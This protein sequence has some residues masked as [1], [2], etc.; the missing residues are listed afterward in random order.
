MKWQRRLENY[1]PKA[2]VLSV[3]ITG[4]N[5]EIVFEYT[6]VE[7]WTYTVN[8]LLEGTQDAVPGS[9]S[10]QDETSDHELAVN[11]KSFEGIHLSI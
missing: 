2:T 6:P 8:Y 4:R 3:K 5:Q 1:Y 10:L 11:F 7:K 9:S